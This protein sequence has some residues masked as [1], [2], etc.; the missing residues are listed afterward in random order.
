M[1][2]NLHRW[3]GGYE[4]ID[5]HKLNRPGLLNPKRTVTKNQS[6]YGVGSEFISAATLTS[7]MT[8]YALVIAE[9]CVAELVDLICIFDIVA[10]FTVDDTS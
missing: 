10:Y 3:F 6:Q 5:D 1:A 4:S 7:F 9:T 8:I 2:S